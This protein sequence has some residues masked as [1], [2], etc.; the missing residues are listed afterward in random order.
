MLSLNLQQKKLDF[1]GYNVGWDEYSLSEKTLQSIR[2]FPM[3]SN[4]TISDICA[5]FGLVN[6]LSPFFAF[7]KVMDPF[8]ELLK[9][10][11]LQKNLLG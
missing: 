11:H 9:T 7:S 5:W 6:Q 1:V 3:P 10:S 2:E 4:P 8:R